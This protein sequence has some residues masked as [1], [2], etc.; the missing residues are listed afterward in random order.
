MIISKTPFRISFFGGATDFPDWFRKHGGA[1][2]STSIDKYCYISCRYHLALST[3]TR[4]RVVWSYVENVSTFAEIL[5]PAVREGLRWMGFDDERGIEI[6][7]QTDLRAR[8]G[9]GSSSAF[10]V[11]LIHALSALRGERPRAQDLALRAIELE[12]EVLKDT[13]GCQDQVA[14]AYGGLNVIRFHEDGSI[15]VCPVEISEERKRELASRIILLYTGSSR[16]SSKIAAS[17]LSS[18]GDRAPMLMKMRGMVDDGR[19]ILESGDLDDFG[20]LLNEA[21]F[22]KRQ[23]S[24]HVSNPGIDAIYA[25]AIEHGALGGKL[26]GAGGTGFM[27]F[28]VPPSRREEVT[29]ALD[30]WPQIPIE[31]E[32]DGSQLLIAQES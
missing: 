11:G 2:L 8:A 9:I 13:V 14:T 7:H 28:Y 12:R 20:R 16:L 25:S 6:H 26:L 17:V 18:I 24:A 5:H 3:E 19:A 1:V 30:Q 22:F 10:A 21:W 29:R 32:N 31:F 4:H 23:L 15:E 27:A